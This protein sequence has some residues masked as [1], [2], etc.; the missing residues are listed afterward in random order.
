MS[1]LSGKKILLGVSGGIAAYKTPTLVRLLIKKGAE[2]KVIITHSAKEFVSP[3]TLSTLS[4]NP[5]Y[6][7]LISED[8]Q[9]PIWNNHVK[10]ASWADIMVIA[11]ATS[12]IISLLANAQCDNIVVAAYL[13]SKCPVF[14]APSMDLDMFSNPS[15]QKNLKYLKKIGKHVLPSP[16]GPL[17]SG[18][19]GKGRMLE[20][21]EIVDL[22]ENIFLSGC[23]LFGKEVL[24][25]AGPTYEKIDPVRFIGN[26]SSGLMG[27]ELA[28]RALSLGA[29]V[30]LISGP[31]NLNLQQNNL[32]L[33]RVFSTQ[34]MYENSI[35]K[36]SSADIVI[37]SAAVSDYTP[38]L[39]Y[40]Q[41][42]KKEK[43]LKSLKL[44]KTI[45]IL[46]FLGENKKKQFLI[47]FALETE[48]S[49]ENAKKKLFKKKL[50]A[51]I[52]NSITDKVSCFGSD[53]SQ[54]TYIPKKGK[55]IPYGLKKKE[56]IAD[57]IFNNIL[58]DYEKNY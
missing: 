31:S 27:F 7:K 23:P 13:S 21:N 41:K 4:N 5:V 20:P 34:E 11:P 40:N 38:E 50:D 30:N 17:A 26:L 57:D 22:V 15:N 14:I 6:D 42:I 36:F 35:K 10:M 43:D 16:E 58:K 28:K 24:I 12:N 37:F 3:L 55:P 18:L 49:I 8:D 33:I 52:L 56:K 1:V 53:K 19:E 54:I 45:D 25:T 9:N 47:G 29:K 48:K 39:Y 44:K 2:V 51:I 46:A 32:D